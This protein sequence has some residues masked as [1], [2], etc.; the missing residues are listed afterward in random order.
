[1]GF[2]VDLSASVSVGFLLQEGIKIL[3]A[4]APPQTNG[5]RAYK[6]VLQLAVR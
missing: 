6:I 2:R 1:M 3:S 4:G 5:R